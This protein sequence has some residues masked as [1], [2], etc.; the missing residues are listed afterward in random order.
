MAATTQ[1][2]AR[3]EDVSRD[4]TG[5]KLVTSITG[6][7]TAVEN[8]QSGNGE[9]TGTISQGLKTVQTTKKKWI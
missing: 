2:S 4:V 6:A 3:T 7:K 8:G 1:K 5:T 9:S